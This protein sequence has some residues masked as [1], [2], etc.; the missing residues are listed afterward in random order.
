MATQAI[1]SRKS[2]EQAPLDN[3]GLRP[4]LP[5]SLCNMAQKD[6]DGLQGWRK[7]L[8]ENKLRAV[9]IFWATSVAGSLAYQYT[10]P[11]PT[12]MKIIHARV[13]AQAFTLAALGLAGLVDVYEHRHNTNQELSKYEQKLQDLETKLAEA[14][15]GKSDDATK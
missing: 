5:T 13:Y 2:S 6:S 8:A 1:H 11:I 4:L 7:W 12:Q 14:V 3:L 15:F 10:K 9:G